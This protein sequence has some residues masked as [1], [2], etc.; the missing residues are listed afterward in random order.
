M[1]DLFSWA[2]SHRIAASLGNCSLDPIVIAVCVIPSHLNSS[3][4]TSCHWSQLFSSLLSHLNFSHLFSS[5]LGFS[6]ISQLFSTL[7]SSPQLM[8]AHLMSS[9]LFSP[10]LTSSKLF[11]HLLSWSQLLSARLTHLSSAQHTLKS[12][13]LLSGPEPAPNKE[14]SSSSPSLSYKS[15]S[16]LYIHILGMVLSTLRNS[17]WSFRNRP[18]KLTEIPFKEANGPLNTEVFT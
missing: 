11:S 13:Q 6:Q 7:L 5:R 9:R 4:L 10:L 8:S 16:R 15:H 2:W 14:S 1:L 18:A 12:P 17:P 3:H